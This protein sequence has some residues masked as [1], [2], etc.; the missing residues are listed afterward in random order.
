MKKNILLLIAL[1]LISLVLVGC[2]EEEGYYCGCSSCD[3]NALNCSKSCKYSETGECICP[4]CKPTPTP[5]IRKVNVISKNLNISKPQTHVMINIQRPEIDGLGDL[6]LQQKINDEISS[7]IIPYED[8]ISNLA[9]GFS[10]ETD[11]MIETKSYKI[12]V[13]YK[14]SYLDDYLSLIVNHNVRTGNNIGTYEDPEKTDGLR[15][16]QWKETYVIDTVNNLRL[17]FADVCDFSNCKFIVTEEINKQAQEQGIDIIF[18][19]GILEIPDNQRFY[20]DGENKKLV[21]YFEP[22]TIAKYVAGEL[23]FEMPF[24]YS[25]STH[26]FVR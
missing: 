20:I 14:T 3:I 4:N 8:E 16:S 12:V 2:D 19:N 13:D 24:T 21:I 1:L 5:V 22:G 17:N 10:V 9:E 25:E 26:K 18:G 6:I 23:F 11:D 15:S 7:A